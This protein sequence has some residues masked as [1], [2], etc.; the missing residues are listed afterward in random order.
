[1]TQHAK[2]R[3]AAGFLLVKATWSSRQR[4]N[5]TLNFWIRFFEGRGRRTSFELGCV[6]SG[7][8]LCFLSP[9]SPPNI[10]HAISMGTENPASLPRVRLPCGT[11]HPG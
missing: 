5:F 8:R 4:S 9:P 11:R 1:M 7:R 6:G 10:S 2:I 3:S